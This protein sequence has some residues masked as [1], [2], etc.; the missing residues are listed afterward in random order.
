MYRTTGA[1]QGIS[2]E[3]LYQE[4]RLESSSERCRFRKDTFL[5][6]CIRSFSV[7]SH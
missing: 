7:I 3:R 1:N 6:D 2:R 5:Q 4:L